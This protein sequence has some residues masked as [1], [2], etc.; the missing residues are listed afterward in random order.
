MQAKN[1]SASQSY[2]DIISAKGYKGF[3]SGFVINSLRVASKQAYRWP[4]NL[5]LINFYQQ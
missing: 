4:L 2:R 5:F 3:Y 1:I